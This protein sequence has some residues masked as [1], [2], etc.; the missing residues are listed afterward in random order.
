MKEVE[1]AVA[2][3]AVVHGPGQLVQGA[4][5]GARIIDGGEEVE[6][7]RVGGAHEFV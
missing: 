6:V 2:A 7:T 1:A 4:Q 3:V 5:A